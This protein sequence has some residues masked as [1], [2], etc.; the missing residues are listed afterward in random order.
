MRHVNKQ[1]SWRRY[2]WIRLVDVLFII[3]ILGIDAALRSDTNVLGPRSTEGTGASTEQ[4]NIEDY[5]PGTFELRMEIDSGQVVMDMT[6]PP[7]NIYRYVQMAKQIY[8]RER[9]TDD[10]PPPPPPPSV[11]QET[12]EITPDHIKELFRYEEKNLFDLHTLCVPYML[13]SDGGAQYDRGVRVIARHY[14]PT[15]FQDRF[16]L[17]KRTFVLTIVL[18]FL[19]SFRRI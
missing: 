7:Q 13:T 2:V 12:S 18:S 3:G 15:T 14:D 17:H 16:G 9:E 1:Q 8:S 11:D 10:A 6:R 19:V 4:T 5:W